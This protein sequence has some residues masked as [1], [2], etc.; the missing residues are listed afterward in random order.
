MK[1]QKSIF[2]L[3][4]KIAVLSFIFFLVGTTTTFAQRGGKRNNDAT[5][6]EKAEKRSQKW[7]TE[8]NLNDTQTAQ[9]KTALEK[10][11]TATDALKGQERSEEKRTQMKA[12]STEF[13]STVKGILTTDQYAA[14]QAKKEEKKAKMKERKG[15]RGTREQGADND[16]DEFE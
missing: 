7:K 12:I 1:S 15:K 13:D 6:T 16:F 2:N 5:P 14:Y 8:F 11:I 3:A 10:R 9:V 4:S